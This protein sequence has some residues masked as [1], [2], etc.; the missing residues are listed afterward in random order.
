MISVNSTCRVKKA[1]RNFFLLQLDWMFMHFHIKVY[2]PFP[3]TNL[4]TQLYVWWYKCVVISN[5]SNF[6][7]HGLANSMPLAS[8]SSYN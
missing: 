3:Q 6:K 5:F 1:T 4:Q 7:H 8:Q 2:S